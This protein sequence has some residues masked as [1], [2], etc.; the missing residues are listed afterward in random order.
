MLYHE[1]I[2]ENLNPIV[3]YF[4]FRPNADN[5]LRG[6]FHSDSIVKTGKTPH[7]NFSHYSGMDSLLDDAKSDIDPRRQ[8]L[9]WE[10]AQIKLLSQALVFPLF[11]IRQC[12]V[13]RDYVNYGH[14]LHFSLSDYPQFNETTCLIHHGGVIP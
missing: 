9:L 2:R 10:Q 8:V 4:T 1:K 7:T 3:L 13:R 6:F 12:T 11:N 14:V 5:Y